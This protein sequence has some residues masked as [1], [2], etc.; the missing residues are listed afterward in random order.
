MELWGAEEGHLALFDRRGGRS[1][2][3]RLYRREEAHEGRHIT[4]WGL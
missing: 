1:W 3:E 4:I 2:P